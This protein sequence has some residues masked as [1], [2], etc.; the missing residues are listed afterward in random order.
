MK[1]QSE[2][3]PMTL[4]DCAAGLCL[5]ITQCPCCAFLFSGHFTVPR[6]PLRQR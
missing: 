4:L 5:A 1:L 6:A 2:I 3:S